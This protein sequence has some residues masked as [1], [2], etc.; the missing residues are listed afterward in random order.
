MKSK[1]SYIY[2]IG[3]ALV[4]IGFCMPVFSV[5]FGSSSGW[6]FVGDKLNGWTIGALLIFIGA[7]AGIVFSF[8]NVKNAKLIKLI[9]LV[10]SIIGGIILIIYASD[11][12]V[13]KS[14]AK[15]LLKN[16]R[17]GFWMIVA[18]WVAGII[19]YITDK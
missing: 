2:L 8:L 7:A 5:L 19:G 13:S 3:M 4:A 14:I 16:T 15:L 6:D 12:F 9:C 10:A 18:G 17:I 1:I 11:N